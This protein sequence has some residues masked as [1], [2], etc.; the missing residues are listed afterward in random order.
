MH[1]KELAL[2]QA[3]YEAT[4]ARR[5]YDAV[6]A[7]NRLVAAELER[8]WN[9]TL[10]VQSQLEEELLAIQR[11]VPNPLTAT[12]KEELLTMAE[13][14]PRL[15]NHPKSL[16]EYKKRIL[17]AV[18]K[19][20]IA[21]TEGD[22]VQLIIH[23]QGGDHTEAQFPK[24]RT[25]QHRYS[26]PQD[27]IALI[28]ALAMIQPDS[29]IASILNRMKQKTAHDQTWTAKHVC[30][31]RSHHAIA[32]YSEEGRRSREEMTVPEVAARLNV[33]QTTVLRM[34]RQRRINATQVCANA[35]WILRQ[36]E[37]ES[38]LRAACQGDS[39]TTPDQNELTLTI[40]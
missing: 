40:Q 8:R 38:L 24:A 7:T 13:D 23:W 5:Q 4:R 3:R 30:T 33:T 10:K 6:D 15:W 2:T 29:M 18:L 11:E 31:L 26:T 37:V 28:R 9:E 34:I 19:E 21:R 36:E 1:H 35:P 12:I 22:T 16:P 14:L 20:V 25:G 27:T 39:P 32:V 17:R